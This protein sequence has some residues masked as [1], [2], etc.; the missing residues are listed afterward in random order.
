MVQAVGG[1]RWWYDTRAL[2]VHGE[3]GGSGASRLA[4]PPSL[5][6]GA[7][8]GKWEG[9]LHDEV[10]S[11]LVKDEGIADRLASLE[12]RFSAAAVRHQHCYK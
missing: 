3:S 1:T 9:V 4:V 6:G 10:L 2:L 12:Q 7:D 8:R 11:E 5:A